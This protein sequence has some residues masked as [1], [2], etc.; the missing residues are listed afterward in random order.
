[1]ILWN[2]RHHE[3]FFPI[4]PAT[5][6]ALVKGSCKASGLGFWAQGS[7]E[8]RSSREKDPKEI[9]SV[10]SPSRLFATRA[11]LCFAALAASWL[12]S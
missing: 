10:L 8:L 9:F 1:M 12:N 6:R 11:M 4:L 3:Q 7:V 5:V 2:T